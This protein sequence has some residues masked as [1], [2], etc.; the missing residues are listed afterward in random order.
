MAAIFYLIYSCFYM[1][2]RSLCPRCQGT[3]VESPF[4]ATH[5]RPVVILS[6]IRPE[7]EIHTNMHVPRS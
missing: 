7:K 3:E 4:S 1:G 5:V 6:G 2:D